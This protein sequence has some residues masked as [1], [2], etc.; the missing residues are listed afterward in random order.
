ML[1]RSPAPESSDTVTGPG[2]KKENPSETPG[3]TQETNAILEAPGQAS[4]A[5]GNSTDGPAGSEN[6]GP[7]A[8]SPQ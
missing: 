4:G 5:S 6:G 1:F 3:N 8:Q 2:A 7:G